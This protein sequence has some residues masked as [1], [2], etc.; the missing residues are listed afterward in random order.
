VPHGRYGEQM[1]LSWYAGK[2]V[3]ITGHT[4][5]KGVWLSFIL[6]RAGAL[7]TGYALSPTTPLFGIVRNDQ[8]ASEIG[9]IRDRDHL[10]EVFR[11]SHPD[12]VF[13]LAAQPLVLEGYRNPALTFDTNVMGTVN[14]LECV[15]LADWEISSVINV[16][17]DKVYENN[18]WDWPYRETDPLNGHDPYSNSKSCS[19]LVT[20]CYRSSLVDN[21]IPLSTA[22]AGNVIGGGDFADNRIIPDCIRSVIDG[23]VISVRNP[24]SV[25]PYQHVLEPLSAYLKLAEVTAQNSS[26]ASAYNVGPRD[27]DYLTTGEL[28]TLFCQ[29]WGEGARWEHEEVDNPPESQLL[30]LDSSR[31][32]KILGWEPRWGIS[33][34]VSATVDWAKAWRRG[35]NIHAVMDHQI[36]QYFSAAPEQA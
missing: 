4:G 31:I 29:L 14:L 24:H 13:H 5:F 21:S 35:D 11:D 25:R 3:F 7:V 36:E 1:D 6:Q 8:I 18:E 9:D 10:S 30:R 19:E 16:T 32:R 12:I 26:L 27:S 34:A 2:R 28:A 33:Q 20:S 15:R 23:S 17:T 22:R